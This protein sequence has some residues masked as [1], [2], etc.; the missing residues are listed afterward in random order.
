MGGQ[1]VELKARKIEVFG[2][3]DASKYPISKNKL[4]LE[5]LR[6]FPHLRIRTRTIAAVARVRNTCSTATLVFNFMDLNTF[7]HLF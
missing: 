7:I 3:V 2:D 1:K 4:T 6:N 5:H